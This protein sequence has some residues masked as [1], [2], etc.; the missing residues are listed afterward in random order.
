MA[1]FTEQEKRDLSDWARRLVER[2][3]TR[4]D[5]SRI[6]GVPYDQLWK[7]TIGM[8]AAR[9]KQPKRQP[10]VDPQLKPASDPMGK[11]TIAERAE[12]YAGRYARGEEL[13]CELDDPVAI[14][15]HYRATF[16]HASW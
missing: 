12:V 14:D 5:A 11:L 1:R 16:I 6:I 7:W 3:V 2:G 4:Q 10:D 15:G 9:K 8:K 13:F